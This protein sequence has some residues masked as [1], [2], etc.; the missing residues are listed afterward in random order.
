[1]RI[2]N[3]FL[4]IACAVALSLTGT[5]DAFA[6][7]FCL[8]LA[9]SK[10]SRKVVKSTARCPKG[11]IEIINVAPTAPSTGGVS[12]YGSGVGGDLVTPAGSS[13]LDPK[14]QYGS[15]TIS[16]GSNVVVPSG[17]VVRCTGKLTVAGTLTIPA[18]ANG[19]ELP[20]TV[21]GKTLLA[22]IIQPASAS[23]V[24]PAAPGEVVIRTGVDTTNPDPI[25]GAGGSA[26]DAITNFEAL[27]NLI[28]PSTT[29]SGSGGAGGLGGRGGNG[30]GSAGFYCKGG[31]EI[32]GS[33]VVDASGTAGTNG[34]GGGSGGLVV[35]ATNGSFTNSGAVRADGGNG[36]G[37]TVSSAGGG[38]GGGG[39]VNI[40]ASFVGIG[41]VSTNGGA[42]AGAVA[43][44]GVSAVYRS[45][46]GAGGNF[47]GP[48]GAGGGVL[49][50]DNSATAS[51][52]G[53]AGVVFQII[54][55]G[56]D[57]SGLLL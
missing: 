3:S 30:G 49:N 17:S 51:G 48:G 24:S 8:K 11:F 22:Q 56:V 44:G 31:V 43:P 46:G 18:I 27:A 35:F 28:T 55:P 15:I 2:T 45:G 13:I 34:G 37:A 10:L 21:D 7:K 38:G 54:Q 23:F 40:I 14:K 53:S 47:G 50:S 12:P 16:A 25:T 20:A 42:A 41:N 33:G 5:S 1:M 57:V 36:G 9:K 6:D 26:G 39:V 19:G 29:Y 32:Q 4:A 52:P